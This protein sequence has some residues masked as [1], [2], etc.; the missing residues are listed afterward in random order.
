MSIILVHKI[1]IKHLTKEAFVAELVA[2]D[3]KESRLLE[4]EV[5]NAGEDAVAVLLELVLREEVRRDVKIT[6]TSQ[7]GHADKYHTR[8]VSCGSPCAA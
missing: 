1:D 5:G 4:A 2:Y 3:A 8:R 7:R 6:A